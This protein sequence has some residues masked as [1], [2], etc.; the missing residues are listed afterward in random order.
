MTVEQVGT[1]LT[2]RRRLAWNVAAIAVFTVGFT[3][4]TLLW[5]PLVHGARLWVVPGDEWLSV[6]PARYIAEGRYPMLYGAQRGFDALPLVALVLSPFVAIGD[7]LRLA[8]VGAEP[9]LLLVVGPVGALAC[10]LVAPATRAF[11]WQMGVRRRLWLLQATVLVTCALPCALWG[12]FEDALAM[13]SLLYTWRAAAQ[14]RWV[15]AAMWCSLAV[16]SKEWAV[17]AVPFLIVLTPAGTRLRVLV[18]SAAVPALLVAPCLV[19]DFSLTLR[20]IFCSAMPTVSGWDY[21]GRFAGTAG[22]LAVLGAAPVV[23]VTFRRRGVGSSLSIV[24]AM[25]AARVIVEPLLLSYYVAA[26]LTALLAAVV[27]AKGCATA[28]DLVLIV[29]P[30]LWILPDVGHGV[31][32]WL[33]LAVAAGGAT[34]PLWRARLPARHHSQ[35]MAALEERERARLLV[36]AERAASA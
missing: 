35:G 23:A 14:G 3:A 6:G 5:M 10:S 11:A 27:A 26:P 20:A 8:Q 29:L 24:A 21:L 9:S 2:D 33:G 32:W 7:H 28:R 17:L 15:T 16:A 22:R 30:M 13:A 19:G 36:G 34:V 4:W 1:A 25:F 12:H 18:A 31:A